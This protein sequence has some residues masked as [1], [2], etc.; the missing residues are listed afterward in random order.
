MVK[1]A[2]IEVVVVVGG[3]EGEGE[4]RVINDG[5]LRLLLKV[6]TFG[7]GQLYFHSLRCVIHAFQNKIAS[8]IKVVKN[9]KNKMEIFLLPNMIELSETNRISYFPLFY[10]YFFQ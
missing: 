9:Q 4:G 5:I 3:G 6:L 8:L 7:P 10:D 2:V 1:V